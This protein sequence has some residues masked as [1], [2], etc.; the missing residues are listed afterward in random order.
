[1]A[2]TYILRLVIPVHG[3]GRLAAPNGY[4]NR[5]NLLL[6]PSGVLCS[7]CL[8]IRAD[9]IIVL[10]LT[11]KTMIIGALFALQ[12]HMFLLVGISETVLQHAIYEWLVSKLCPRPHIGKVVRRIGHALRASCNNNVCVASDDGL[13]SH[14]EGLDR[15]GTD[16]VDGRGNS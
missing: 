10:I 11:A 1:M 7:D 4:F 3:N 12:S 6:E 14:N 15:G 2:G 16:L 13:G 8:L 5:R 9:T